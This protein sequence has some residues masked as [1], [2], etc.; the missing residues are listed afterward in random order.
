MIFLWVCRLSRRSL[1]L[2]A[3]PT[4]FSWVEKYPKKVP[5]EK[6]RAQSEF[7]F[8]KAWRF[9]PSVCLKKTDS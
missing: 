5:S 4:V 6:K 2:D 9:A 3:V 7:E 8:V 1:V